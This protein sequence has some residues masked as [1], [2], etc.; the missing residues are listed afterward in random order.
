MA[1]V[2]GY[3]ST[4]SRLYDQAMHELDD[5]DLIQAS[6]KL[7]GAAAQALKCIAESRG[8]K[9]DSHGQLYNILAAIREETNDP[10]IRRHFDA[11]AVLHTNFYE[12][13]LDETGIRERANEVRLFIEKIDRLRG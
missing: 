13:W 12:N 10:D 6:E 11:A 3:R 8:W 4:S 7:W 9:H 1:T 5:G 2:E